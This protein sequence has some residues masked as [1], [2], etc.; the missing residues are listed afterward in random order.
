MDL[1][2]KEGSIVAKNIDI[3]SDG[4]FKVTGT[5]TIQKDKSLTGELE[6]GLTNPYIAWLPELKTDI[7]YRADGDYHMTTVHVSGTAKK[8]QQD[9]APRVT[10]E[11]SKHPFVAL[12]LFFN[13]ASEWF[14]FD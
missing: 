7:F 14:D 12:K 10:Q 1:E 5:V 4:V 3:E 6:L 13:S 9:L 2:W 8:P 11:I